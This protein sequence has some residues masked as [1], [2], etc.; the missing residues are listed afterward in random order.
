MVEEKVKRRS[1]ANVLDYKRTFETDHGRRV[2]WDLMKETGMNSSNF[3]PSDPYSTAYNEGGRATVL[4][5]LS[6]IN[7]NFAKLEKL[8]SK[9]QQ[10]DSSIFN[11]IDG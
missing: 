9:G 7:T 1:L 8:I 6:K 3:V 11:E 5:I 2:L 4:H 10:D